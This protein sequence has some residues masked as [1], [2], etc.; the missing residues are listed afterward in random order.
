MDSIHV[1][2]KPT[3]SLQIHTHVLPNVLQVRKS[4]RADGGWRG[5]PAS[6]PSC[7]QNPE[8]PPPLNW[9]LFQRRP[10]KILMTP[11][12]SLQKQNF[13]AFGN[14]IDWDDVISMAPGCTALGIPSPWESDGRHFLIL[15]VTLCVGLFEGWCVRVTVR[16][17]PE[18]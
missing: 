3:F 14:S 11:A 13:P 7:A 5:C 18:P 4:E 6:L 2:V 16:G 10:H 8:A 17:S 12:F 9:A 15:L 1:H